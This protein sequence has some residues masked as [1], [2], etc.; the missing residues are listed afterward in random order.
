MTQ[1]PE[2]AYAPFSEPWV[3]AD[4]EQQDKQ[5][6]EE[7]PA[8]E[9]HS[10]SKTQTKE[11]QPTCEPVSPKKS[12][13]DDQLEAIIAALGPEVQKYWTQTKGVVFGPE[14][15]LDGNGRM[16]PSTARSRLRN[17]GASFVHSPP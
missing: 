5:Q 11:G 8:C 3:L 13:K 4:V 9:V 1:L 10:L 15:F 7:Q 16:T 14:I 12:V 6:L 2:T 17:L